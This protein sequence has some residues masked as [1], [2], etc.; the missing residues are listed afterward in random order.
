MALL[1]VSSP[2]ERLLANL[3]CN[4]ADASSDSPQTS[5]NKGEESVITQFMG[6]AKGAGSAS[7]AQIR[8]KMGELAAAGQ[9]DGAQSR[10]WKSILCC[11][12]PQGDEE[13]KK[14]GLKKEG[15]AETR[16][17]PRRVMHPV[18]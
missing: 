11:L 4:D 10:I 14:A 15:G 16:P 6:N 13:L 1:P 9:A 7:V 18:R 12:R 8:Q 5:G 2:D 3:D 17:E